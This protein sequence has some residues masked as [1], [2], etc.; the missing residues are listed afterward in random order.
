MCKRTKVNSL[1][2]ALALVLLIGASPAQAVTGNDYAA[3]VNTDS[4]IASYYLNYGLYLASLGYGS[5]STT[6]YYYAYLY[7]NDAQT[8]SSN[9][10]QSN[11]TGYT[12]SS[13]LHQTDAYYAYLYA[14]Y[15]YL[16]WVNATSDLFTMAAGSNSVSNALLDLFYAGYYNGFA[17]YY[18]GLSDWADQDGDGI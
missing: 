5:Y 10:Y 2:M 9:A 4:A 1:L 7:A 3:T 12:Q 11:Y 15:S 16:Y 6:Y 18:G 13:A 8:N 17:A 14:Y